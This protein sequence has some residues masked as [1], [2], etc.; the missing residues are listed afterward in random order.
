MK[1]LAPTLG[2]A[3]VLAMAGQAA[4]AAGTV[5]VSFKPA[6]QYRDV[7]RSSID[8][9]HNLDQLGAHL[10][11]LAPRLADGQ[12]LKVEVLDVDLAGEVRPMR[13]GDDLRV[14][15]GG[16]DWPAMQLRWTLSAGE[17]TVDSREERIAD[18]SYLMH[19]TRG[20][21]DALVYE[22][23]M[24]DEWFDARFGAAAVAQKR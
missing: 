15:R 11:S 4:Q 19:S 12:V 8:G 18:M 9:Q 17:R 3:L 1:R 5:E 13:R 22:K 7:G 16:A 23:R 24:L 2:A 6:D 20:S 10:K 21:T 14:L